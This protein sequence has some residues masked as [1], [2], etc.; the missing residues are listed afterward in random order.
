[1]LFYKILKGQSN[2]ELTIRSVSYEEMLFNWDS[3]IVIAAYI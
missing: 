1:M 3:I 2:L